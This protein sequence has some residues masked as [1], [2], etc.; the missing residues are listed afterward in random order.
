[1]VNLAGG[2]LPTA[3]AGKRDSC[4]FCSCHCFK[5]IEGLLNEGEGL[6]D[7]SPFPGYAFL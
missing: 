4:Q 3:V 5:I 1:M 7:L 2:W 6:G